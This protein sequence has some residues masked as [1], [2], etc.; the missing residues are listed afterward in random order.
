MPSHTKPQ[1]AQAKNNMFSDAP[2]SGNKSEDG[3]NGK[4]KNE[5]KKKKT[6]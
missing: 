2:E 5:I 6:T 4:N 1:V 3:K